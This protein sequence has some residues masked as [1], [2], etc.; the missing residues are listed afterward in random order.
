MDVEE[1]GAGI[2][3]GAR[4]EVRNHFEG[5]WAKGFEVVDEHDG[6]VRLRRVSDGAELPQWFGPTDLRPQT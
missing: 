4:V 6:A 5:G 2:A 3:P 1:A